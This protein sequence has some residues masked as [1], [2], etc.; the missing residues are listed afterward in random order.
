MNFQEL[1]IVKLMNENPTKLSGHYQSKLITKIQNRFKES[2][3]KL[4]LGSFY[5]YL[6][7]HPTRDFVVSLDNIWSWMGFSRKDHCKIVL[8]KHF[9]ESVD[10]ITD[11]GF[12]ATSGK[13]LDKKKGGRPSEKILMNV[14]TFKKLCL[15]SKTDK[16]FEIHDYFI[17]MEEIYQETADEESSELRDQI[18]I[19]DNKI[20]KLQSNNENVLILNFRNK[21]VVYFIMIENG[22]IKFGYSKDV[23]DRMKYHR[24]EFGKDIKLIAVFETI[25]N[26]EF[27]TM[28][29]HDKIIKP[30]II[31]KEYK[32]NQT[33]LIQ[34]NSEFTMESLNERIEF[35]KGIVN[36]DLVNKLMLENTTLKA[37]ISDLKTKIVKLE[38]LES[39][40]DIEQKRL[41]VRTKE[42]E[43]QQE[44]YK[45]NMKL[46]LLVK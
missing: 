35:L 2:E 21:H 26:R 32:T 44:G 29:K 40:L 38:N 15:V 20:L 12:P 14:R 11:R 36:G 41:K 17:N 3:Q 25:Y 43:A 1:N 4:F 27:E 28:I 10:F 42:A 24:T 9:T 31:N 22:I 5:C 39:T 33:E 19:K 6:N 30:R 18:L 8:D 37:E 34:L 7:Y 13:P 46:L 45:V 16:A 23:E